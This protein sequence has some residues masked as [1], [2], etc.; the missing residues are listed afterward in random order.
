MLFFY[1]GYVPRSM[2]MSAVQIGVDEPISSYRGFHGEISRDD[3][4]TLLQL[5][6]AGTFIIRSSSQGCRYSVLTHL[7]SRYPTQ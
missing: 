7:V 3:A 4:I 5:S 2:V 6:P 1:K